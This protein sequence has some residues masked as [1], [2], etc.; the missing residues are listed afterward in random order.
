MKALQHLSQHWLL[1]GSAGLWHLAIASG[2]MAQPATEP[3]PGNGAHPLTLNSNGAL[4]AW[5]G[6][7][8][9]GKEASSAIA[10][11]IRYGA[12]RLKLDHPEVS[13]G[14]DRLSFTYRWPT[15]AELGVTIHHR[16]TNEH[17]AVLWIREVQTRGPA[18]LA[19]DL[20]V[21]VQGWPGGL[22]T[23]T[24]L[25]R[26]DGT[27]SL[28]E[29]QKAAGFR[30]AGA[31]P[32]QGLLLA[33][34]MVSLPALDK[35]NR[36]LVA[37][38]P[39]F[40]TFFRA[41]ALEWT[42]LAKA[43]L[44]DGRESRTLV[45]VVHPGA[46]EESLGWFYRAL[47][48]AVAPGP[49]WLHEIAMVDFDYHSDEGRGWFRDLD[50]LTAALPESDR[51]Q[52]FLCL[53]GWYDYLGR[54][55]FDAPSG[56]LDREWTVFS[57]YESARAA[58]VFGTIGGERVSMGFGN[59]K[60]GP[61]SLAEV[62]RRLQY[63]RAR[64]FRAGLYF[65]DGVNAGAGLPHFDPACVLQWGG[66]QGPDS[67]GRSYL[68]NPLH[69]KVRAFFLDY[70][71]ALLAE[72]GPDLD[73]LVWDETFHVPCG[74]LGTESCPGYADRAMMRLVREIT[75]LVE[76]YNR[77]HQRQIA[78]LTSDCPGA[79]G[80]ELKAPYALVS[81]GTYQDSWCQPRAWSYG[82]F[83]NY[84]NVLW[85][86]CWWPV[87]KWSRVEFGARQHQA[88]VA[89]SNGWGDDQGFSELSS[90]QRARVLELFHWRKQQPTRLHWFVRLP[91]EA[92]SSAT[93][94]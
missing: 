89:I 7:L 44:E 5:P 85:S 68:Q 71:Q 27:G 61:M 48:P 18:K 94:L 54:Y 84:R 31:L 66:W 38:D 11:E 24:W 46:I 72:F 53:H 34:P 56:R 10:G 93:R 51:H 43:G 58:P 78:F 41:T 28:L 70:A 47:L 91:T 4:T 39:Y 81:H 6:Q 79:F 65:A 87:T 77:R 33:L 49:E 57:S 69:P 52:V 3:F 12:K 1:A 59:C 40:S 14:P 19:S 20:V 29:T 90:S 16:V 83:A 67:K 13:R 23:N 75:A 45:V 26:L 17:G 55:C 73:A 76:D 22:P 82:V 42:Y 92:K 60:P 74:Q 62:H 2:A 63:A 86:C 50:A 88:P 35:A 8:E 15:E 80:E 9:P 36:V 32:G 30:F 37:A 25:P 64:G 21:S